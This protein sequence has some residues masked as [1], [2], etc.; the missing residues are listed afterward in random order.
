LAVAHTR[1]ANG[2]W[3]DT[4]HDLALWKVAMAHHAPLA[5]LGLQI[6]MLCEKL[7]NLRLDRLGQQRTRPA[8]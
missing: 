6:G 3:P 7:S 4:G 8:A 1:L 2:D 5:R